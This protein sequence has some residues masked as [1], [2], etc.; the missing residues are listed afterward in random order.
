MTQWLERVKSAADN[1]A[2][3]NN[4]FMINVRYDQF[5]N[6]IDGTDLREKVQLPCLTSFSPYVEA[7][8][9]VWYCVDK[10]GNEKFWLGDLNK[11][12]LM[13]IWHSGRRKEVLNY[14]KQNP[15]GHI[16]RNSPLNEFL[17]D[18]KNPTP[19]YSFL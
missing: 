13:E 6:Y 1:L 4:G 5:Q 8:G 17:W 3:P 11:T 16:C 9:Q 12:S 15:C 19:F 2:D 18:M 14:V 10:K 7:D